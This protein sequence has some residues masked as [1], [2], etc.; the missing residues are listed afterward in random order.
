MTFRRN[1]L[2]GIIVKKF[3]PFRERF[4]LNY[5]WMTEVGVVHKVYRHWNGIGTRCQSSGYFQ[6]V[7]FEYVAPAFSA[8]YLA[9]ILSLTILAIEFRMK[10]CEKN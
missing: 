4:L 10:K 2:I 5:L 9:H 6:S 1:D 3:L 8:L 7:R